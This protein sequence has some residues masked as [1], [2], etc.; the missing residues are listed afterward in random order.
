LALATISSRA[1]RLL[2]AATAE[3]YNHSRFHQQKYC[4]PKW[5]NLPPDGLKSARL[6]AGDHS[7]KK[8]WRV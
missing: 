8:H 3:R 4:H 1:Q 6:A 5:L 2:A 7:W